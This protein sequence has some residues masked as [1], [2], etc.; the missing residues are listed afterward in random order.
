MIAMTARKGH[1]LGATGLRQEKGTKDLRQEEQEGR[2][3]MAEQETARA[4]VWAPLEDLARVEMM[5]SRVVAPA[6]FAGMVVCSGPGHLGEMESL[7]K[8]VTALVARETPG[9]VVKA[10]VALVLMEVASLET[11]ETALVA[12]ESRQKAATALEVALESR[13]K[14]ATPMVV[15]V[16]TEMEGWVLVV[17]AS[18]EAQEEG[19]ASLV[20]APQGR[21]AMESVAQASLEATAWALVQ[22]PVAAM[23][24]ALVAPVALE[25]PERV[26]MVKAA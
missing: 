17:P 3:G 26:L 10:M 12:L 14:A 6:P 9:E 11:A 22:A 18:R 2:E 4:A 21:A 24:M 16:L 25:A 13:E 20:L 23:A 19:T 7:E 8:V 5:A 15:L 1:H